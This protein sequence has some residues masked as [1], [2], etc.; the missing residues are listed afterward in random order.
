MTRVGLAAAALIGLSLAPPEAAAQVGKPRFV[1]I[2]DNS[3]SMSANVAGMSTHG[4]GSQSQ[5]GCDLDGK[6]T[7]GWKYDDSKLYQAKAA[8]IDTISAFGS[9]EFALAT[10]ARVLLGQPCQTDADCTAI[11]AGASCVDLPEDATTQKYCVRQMGDPYKECS[12][13]ASCVACAN[14]A[15]TNDRIFEWRQL[16]CSTP[17]AYSSTCPG[18]QVIVGFPA[19]GSNFPDIYRWI[20]GQEDLP[21]FTVTSN[22][23]IRAE[24]WTPLAGSV[25]SVSWRAVTCRQWL[26]AGQTSS[27]G[28]WIRTCFAPLTP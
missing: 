14:P 27:T 23:E 1:F 19:S 7:G 12:L 5:P 11:V 8:I 22:R 9:A 28:G 3:S 20:D 24:A 2:L 26:N 21:P 10:Y 6:S 13:G 16:D 4:D 25:Y 18:A 17:C 15:D